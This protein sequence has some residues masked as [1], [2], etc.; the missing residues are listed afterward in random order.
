MPTG[1]EAG[2]GK[3]DRISFADNDFADLSDERLDTGFHASGMS[4]GLEQVSSAR[5]TAAVFFG[6]LAEKQSNKL[7]KDSGAIA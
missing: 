1:Q 2:N 6:S 5:I 4:D 3:P 7:G